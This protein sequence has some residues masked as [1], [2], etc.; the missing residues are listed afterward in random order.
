MRAPMQ[1]AQVVTM[2]IF[3]AFGITGVILAHWLNAR[4]QRQGRGA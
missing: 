3:Y 2:V 1:T 4:D